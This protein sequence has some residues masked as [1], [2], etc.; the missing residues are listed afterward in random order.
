MAD[1]IKVPLTADLLPALYEAM[2]R[3]TS[4]EFV[5]SER[6]R[7]YVDDEGRD[8]FGQ[9]C[10]AGEWERAKD[11]LAAKVWLD[12]GG[13]VPLVRADRL[14]KYAAHARRL[15]DKAWICLPENERWRIKDLLKNLSEARKTDLLD[16]L[17]AEYQPNTGRDPRDDFKYVD[18]V[19]AKV[20]Q[21]WQQLDKC[22]TGV[23]E[24]E[25]IVKVETE[26]TQVSATNDIELLHRAVSLEA[27]GAP[28]GVQDQIAHSVVAEG[29]EVAPRPKK[30][31]MSWQ[32]ILSA[33]QLDNND[34][35]RSRVRR[36]NESE[37]HPGPIIIAGQGAQP[38]VEQQSLLE[39][40]NGLEEA[41][42]ESAGRQRD[43]AATL[44]ERHPH[45]R[46][47]QVVPNI[48]GSVK[49]RRGKRR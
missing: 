32:E 47:G 3:E 28:A 27:Q 10:D 14:A 18:D 38:K 49:P 9:I 26:V 7:G 5:E 29:D 21:V 16:D 17:A 40:W 13:D 34:E 43:R 2:A 37:K 20:P 48:R 39:W 12:S 15:A 36:L 8:L 4:S 35:N 24:I 11:E 41:F 45:G 30:Y 19:L 25:R 42:R 33:L 31:L 6:E 44:E 1:K 46:D 22:T 23:R